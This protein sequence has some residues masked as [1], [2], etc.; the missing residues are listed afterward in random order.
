MNAGVA[1]FAF[2]GIQAVVK[3]CNDCFALSKVEYKLRDILIAQIRV[4]ILRQVGFDGQDTVDDVDNDCKNRQMGASK[5][6][7]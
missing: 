1:F 2:G 6:S 4:N 5:V 3:A 7:S